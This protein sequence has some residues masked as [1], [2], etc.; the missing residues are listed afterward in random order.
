MRLLL[1]SI[2]NTMQLLNGVI[3]HLCLKTTKCRYFVFSLLLVWGIS[4]FFFLH[5]LIHVSSLKEKGYPRPAYSFVIN[6]PFV[7]SW[8]R[9]SSNVLPLMTSS[10]QRP[11]T[12]IVCLR[13]DCV[14][15]CRLNRPFREGFTR[16]FKLGLDLEGLAWPVC[17][18]N[19]LGMC[20]GRHIKVEAFFPHVHI[21]AILQNRTIYAKYHIDET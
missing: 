2:K 18:Y 8:Q 7:T 6:R 20:V 21:L 9:H 11:W 12:W 15:R 3:P 1:S 19:R 13:R 4:I 16:P 17:K 10:I 14:Y 5:V